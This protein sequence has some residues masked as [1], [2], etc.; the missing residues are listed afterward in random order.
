MIQIRKNMIAGLATLFCAGS[1]FA[2][3]TSTS[4]NSG[5]Y[6]TEPG[7]TYGSP[8]ST[9]NTTT[10]TDS[11]GVTTNTDSTTANSTMPSDS[12]NS[13][14]T[15]HKS[16]AMK[17]HGSKSSAQKECASDDTA[18]LKSQDSAGMTEQ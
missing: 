10:A 7:T 11:K 3:T 9:G 12:S 2:A 13:T 4:D 18:C 17:R 1:L 14:S 15:N 8:S 5:L 6:N 16:S